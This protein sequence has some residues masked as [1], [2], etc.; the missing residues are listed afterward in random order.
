MDRYRIYYD[1][2]CP[3]C[4]ASRRWVEAL[5][6]YGQKEFLDVNQ[7]A[8]LAQ[9]P[10]AVRERAMGQMHLRLPDGRVLGGF[11][12]VVALLERMP[13]LWPLWLLLRLPGMTW[14]G[15]RVYSAVARHRYALSRCVG[16]VCRR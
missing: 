8:H 1:G 14:L 6:W 9:L 7:A 15:G 5:A 4:M 16:A 13:L 11:D 12:A 3:I 2:R 10:P